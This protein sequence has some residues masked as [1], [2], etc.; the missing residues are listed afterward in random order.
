MEWNFGH[1]STT[2]SILKPTHTYTKDGIYTAMLTLVNL[3]TYTVYKA[4]V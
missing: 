3:E 1:G 4:S 2:T